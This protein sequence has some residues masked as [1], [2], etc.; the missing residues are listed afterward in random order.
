MRE[1]DDRADEII[2]ENPGSARLPGSLLFVLLI[3]LWASGQ[4]SPQVCQSV[5]NAAEEDMKVLVEHNR[6]RILENASCRFFESIER[7]AK[8]GSFGKCTHNCF[9]DFMKVLPDMGFAAPRPTSIPFKAIAAPF[10]QYIQQTIMWP[11]VM[12]S[13]HFHLYRQQFNRLCA[14]AAMQ[15][16][17][18]G[19]KCLGIRN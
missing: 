15:F 17:N 19:M 12:F 8:I 16:N 1:S 7:L 4:L 5:V 13:Q 9:R 11:H 3:S 10:H 6:T 14:R 2:S 18:F